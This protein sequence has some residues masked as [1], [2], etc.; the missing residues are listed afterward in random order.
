MSTTATD[1]RERLIDALQALQTLEKNLKG[2]TRLMKEVQATGD[3]RKLKSKLDQLSK[4][5][6]KV[7]DLKSLAGELEQWRTG[8]ER[9]RPMRFGRDLKEAAEEAG[10]TFASL[11]ADPPSYRLDPLTVEADFGKGTAR[12]DYARLPLGECDL[13]PKSILA[14][15]QKMLAA[16]EGDGFVPEEYFERLHEAYRRCAIG[17]SAGERVELA[18]LLPE[19]AFLM[20]DKRFKTDPTRD[21]FRPYGKVRLAYDLSRLRRAGLLSH[22]GVRL[23]LG[24]ATLGTTK[25]KD[26]V[27]FLE[28]IAG[29][30][31]YYLSVAFVQ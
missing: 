11:T 24:V 23:T 20:Q 4:L 22:K 3:I 30:G 15:R 27:L 13:D 16:L 19:L 29:K 26:R 6:L 14:H 17:K 31:Q 8:E 5:E 2:A 1:P 9:G 21:H 12:L 18:D 10:V 25:S 28:D 7:P